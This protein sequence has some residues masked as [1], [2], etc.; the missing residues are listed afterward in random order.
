MAGALL[1]AAKLDDLITW[2]LADYE[3]RAVS[4]ANNPEI[5]RAYRAHLGAVRES[6]AL[7]DTPLFVRN[8][9]QILLQLVVDPATQ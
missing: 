9:E 4:I 8:L 6:G 5:C 7:F 1:S 2:S 3:A